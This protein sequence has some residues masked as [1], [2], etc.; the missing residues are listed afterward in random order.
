[1][2]ILIIALF[3]CIGFLMLVLSKF[4]ITPQYQLILTALSFALGLYVTGNDGYWIYYTFLFAVFILF[5]YIPYRKYLKTKKLCTVKVEKH[6]SFNKYCFYI[7]IAFIA[8]HY[9]VGG[10]PILSDSV[11]TSRFDN[12]SSG[13]FGIPGRMALFGKLFILFYSAYF[14][15]NENYQGKKYKRYFIIAIVVNVII[16]VFSGSKSSI[17]SLIELAIFMF[18]FIPK[19]INIRRFLKPKIFI[20]LILL[21]FCA[22]LYAKHFFT[23]YNNQFST[24]NFWSYV[25]YR[26][27]NL[28]VEGGDYI[29]RHCNE[30]IT[31]LNDFVY[32]IS[33]YLHLEL[34]SS[35]SLEVY[36]SCA[37]NH[38][39]YSNPYAFYVPITIG[40]IPETIYHF[41]WF[42]VVPIGFFGFFYGKKYINLKKSKNPIEYM[43]LCFLIWFFN[44]FLLKGNLAYHI[45]NYILILI[46]VNGIEY[47]TRAVSKGTLK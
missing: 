2:D 25:Y 28:T 38:F 8:Y 1:M 26:S 17:L 6:Y 41:G 40:G 18:S 10:I 22:V 16:A 31:Y 3:F 29:L 12:T 46:I 34:A 5:T 43:N 11:S 13:L 33:K 7:I 9:A 27:T 4:N 30:R 23:A 19:N 47:L 24:M 36:A 21:F 44:D 32:Y 39:S 15:F 37:I 42:S 35:P 20:P 14:V 45:I